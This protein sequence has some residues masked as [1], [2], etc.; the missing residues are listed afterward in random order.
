MSSFFFLVLLRL[1]GL[2]SSSNLAL[3][4]PVSCAAESARTFNISVE[5]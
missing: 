2:Y 4:F 1:P 3:F 5:K